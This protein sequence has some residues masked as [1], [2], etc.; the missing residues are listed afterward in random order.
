MF[1]FSAKGWCSRDESIRSIR[2]SPVLLLI[3]HPECELTIPGKLYEYMA[4]GNHI[5]ALTGHQPEIIRLLQ[6]YGN[7]TVLPNPSPGQLVDVLETLFRRW[8]A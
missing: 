4:S 5:L 3:R 6:E 2:R 1:S 8:E 7:A